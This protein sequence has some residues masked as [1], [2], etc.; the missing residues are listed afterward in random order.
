MNSV[1]VGSVSPSL[2]HRKCL[3]LRLRLHL[4]PR[5]QAARQVI[6]VRETDDQYK[7]AYAEAW[8]SFHLADMVATEEELAKSR[9]ESFENR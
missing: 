1:A 3:H 7:G 5:F 9:S 2:L 8:A 6:V 4:I